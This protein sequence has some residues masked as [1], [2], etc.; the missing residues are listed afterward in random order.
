MLHNKVICE[1]VLGGRTQ[2]H[3][4]LANLDSSWTVTGSNLAVN[5]PWLQLYMAACKLLDAA[6][7]LPPTV[8]PQFQL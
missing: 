3:S 1:N 2:T 8:H 6:L 7:V 5:Q 4:K